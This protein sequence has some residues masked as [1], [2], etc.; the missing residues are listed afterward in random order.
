MFSCVEFQPGRREMHARCDRRKRPG[1]APTMLNWFWR[2]TF[3]VSGN[4][5]QAQNLGATGFRDSNSALQP[6]LAS[7]V[8]PA[9]EKPKRQANTFSQNQFRAAPAAQMPTEQ[10]PILNNPY[11]EPALALRHESSGGTGLFASGQRPPHLHAG[12]PDDPGS[13][14]RARRFDGIERSRGG[15]PRVACREP[16]PP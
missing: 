1:H 13:P 16:S 8:S 15:G 12:N 10:N 4:V 2:R 7:L 14:R 3:M 11:E 9:S 5:G 6:P